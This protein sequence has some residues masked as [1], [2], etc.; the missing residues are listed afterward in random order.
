M[1][2][3]KTLIDL[4]LKEDLPQGDITT[5]SLQQADRLGQAKLVAKQDLVLSGTK[6]F[7]EVYKTIDPE[8]KILWKNKNGQKVKKGTTL[9]VIQGKLCSLLI[10]ERVALNFLGHLSGIATLTHQFV[11]LSKKSKI[12]DTRKTL[13]GLRFLEKAAVVDGGGVNHRMSLSD[14][15]LIKENHIRTAGGITPAITQ[16]RARF[17]NQKLEVEVTNLKELKEALNLK[18]HRIMLD[19]M[20]LSEMKQ[21]VKI[22]KNKCELEASG[23]V[24][25][26]NVK[27]I[28]E[29]GVGFISVGKI[30]H[31][32]PTAD[33]SILHEFI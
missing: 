3:L 13:P 6:A 18:P 33:L 30:T 31:S 8:T 12:T 20:S 1:N 22:V 29:T 15:I 21:A 14:Q 2:D 11:R 7:D 16:C 17:P 10:A 28:S 26:K 32:A 24:N 27:K 23:N 4:A 9:C 5:D 25:L 19:N